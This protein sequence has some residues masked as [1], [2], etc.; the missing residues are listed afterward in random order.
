MDSVVSK[1]DEGLYSRQMY[2]YDER[3]MGK[4]STAVV[5]ITHLTAL[6]T[7][8]V[9]NLAL[10]GVKQIDIVNQGLFVDEYEYGV[11]YYITSSDVGKSLEET[12]VP[13]LRELNGYVTINLIDSMPNKEDLKKYNCVVMVDS[14]VHA[15]QIALNNITHELNVPFILAHT[16]GLTGS[17]FCDFGTQF[18][19]GDT[20][21][22]PAKNVAM[23]QSYLV[24]DSNS[25]VYMAIETANNHDLS[26][27]DLVMLHNNYFNKS[28]GPYKVNKCPKSDILYLEKGSDDC[29]DFKPDNYVSYSEVHQIKTGINLDFKSLELSYKEPQFVYNDLAHFDRP[30]QL[31]KILLTWNAFLVK[32]SRVP[33]SFDDVDFQEFMELAKSFV[34]VESKEVLDETLFKKFIN[35]GNGNIAPVISVIGALTS[36]EV[37]KAVTNKYMPIQ[38]FLHFE[39]FDSLPDFE[40]LSKSDFT[41]DSND[42]YYSNINVFGKQ[43][44]EQVRKLKLFMV[45]TGAI[46]CELLKN[47]AQMGVGTLE[48]G[49]IKMTDMDTIER[50][51]L[52][53]QFLFRSGDIGKLKS[54]AAKSAVLQMNPE[55]HI[56]ALQDKVCAETE[57]IFNSKFWTDIDIVANALDNIQARLFVD[58]KCVNYRKSLLESGTL[59]TKGNVQVVTP[60]AL[61]QSYGSSY[62]P[63][64]TGIPMCTLKS[65]PHLIDHTIQW[66][67]DKFEELFNVVPNSINRLAN[68]REFV[69]TLGDNDLHQNYKFSKKYGVEDVPQNLV[70]CIVT[71]YKHFVYYYKDMIISLLTCYPPNH[72]TSKGS[73]FWSGSKRCPT[74]LEFNLNDPMHLD[75]VRNFAYLYAYMYGV[76]SSTMSN[77]FIKETLMSAKNIK[78]YPVD[79]KFAADDAE[80]KQLQENKNHSLNKEQMYAELKNMELNVIHMFPHEFEKDDDSNHHIDFITAAS[81]LRAVSYQIAVADRHKTKGIAGRIIPAI[82]TTTALVS[83]L[84]SLELYKLVAKHS[85]VEKYRN[86]F[87]NLAL[88]TMIFSDPIQATKST[89]AGKDYTLWD[90]IEVNENKPLKLRELMEIVSQKLGS[91]IDSVDHTPASL[92][93]FILSAN[94]KAKRLEMYIEDILNDMKINYN[95]GGYVTLQV[96]LEDDSDVIVPDIHYW[97]HI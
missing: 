92:Y 41:T 15:K 38:Q 59:G 32:H 80:E 87:I 21:G 85:N 71:G 63:P 54:E 9:K 40:T 18:H 81:N 42:R 20:T 2:V 17:I 19:V 74:P 61:T 73:P 6:A 22:E 77:E 10:T 45:G 83:G 30:V 11:N 12:L 68:E 97:T 28:E 94:E 67:R 34:D 58:Q 89:V 65:F 84:V 16:K 75:Y 31:H 66:A 82:A 47:F 57:N 79:E 64:E 37:V 33:R 8:I 70:D 52:N 53:R 46:G 76:D 60:F 69:N 44:V 78:Y 5:L 24:T 86:A 93:S 90:H 35:H 4:L 43:F 14:L 7:E 25:N 1:V 95:K 36:Q 49:Y 3:T 88:S 62:D 27:N 72:M 96:D 23:S 50:S 48:N 56:E 39:S 55:L 29:P 13:K 91:N 51:N 26:P